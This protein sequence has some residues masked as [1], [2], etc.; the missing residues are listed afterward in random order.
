MTA[1]CTFSLPSG[2]LIAT[3]TKCDSE[4]SCRD[5][6]I[7]GGCVFNQITPIFPKPDKGDVFMSEYLYP[8][9]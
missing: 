5:I 2:F 4:A 3:M 7:P 1:E 6:L 9:R 8:R